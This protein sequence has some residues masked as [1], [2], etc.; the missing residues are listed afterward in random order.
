MN[1][2][3]KCYNHLFASELIELLLEY[4]FYFYHSY[5]KILSRRFQ[6]LLAVILFCSTIIISQYNI[7]KNTF[8]TDKQ[9]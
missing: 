7:F 9:K 3:L 2:N 6:L 8:Y 4:I 5:F 1:K